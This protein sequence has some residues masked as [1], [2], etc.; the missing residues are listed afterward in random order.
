MAARAASDTGS[1]G[2]SPVGGQAEFLAGA[3]FS[4]VVEL[5]DDFESPLLVLFESPDFESPDLES[6]LVSELLFD[7]ELSDFSPLRREDDGLSV[8]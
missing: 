8:R 5:F 7:A 4:V 1:D 6:V 3:F 2:S